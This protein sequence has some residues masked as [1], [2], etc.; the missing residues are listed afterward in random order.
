LDQ[1]DIM[2]EFASQRRLPQE[3]I[4]LDELNHRVNNEFAAAISIVS[5]AAMAAS[6]D[7]VK[8]SLSRVADMLHRF[9]DVHRALQMPEYDTPVDAASYLRQLCRSISRSQ[10]DGRQIELVL[11]AQ[12]LQLSADHCWRLGMIVFELINNAARH[13]FPGGGGEI[14]VELLRAGAFAQCSVIDNG[15][16]AATVA[17]GRGLKILDELSRSLGGR[18]EQRFGPRGSQSVLVF[19]R[20]SDSTVIAGKPRRGDQIQECAAQ[21]LD[22]SSSAV[23]CGS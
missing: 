13:A 11:A 7:K 16:G 1:E 6:N 18:F 22:D 21:A 5:L 23:A 2:T 3:Q 12:P 8:G 14:R 4:L 20:G 9:A 10:L 17:P 19:S 15:S